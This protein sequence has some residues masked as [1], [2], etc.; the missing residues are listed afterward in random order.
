MKKIKW[1]VY[2]IGLGLLLSF[3]VIGIANANVPSTYTVQSGDSLSGIA[4][5]F[6]GT[7][8]VWKDIYKL[9]PQINNPNLIYIGQIISLDPSIKIGSKSV[10]L[11]PK[12]YSRVEVYDKLIKH[13]FKVN[14]IKYVSREE[15][16]QW[17][18]KSKICLTDYS[19]SNLHEQRLLANKIILYSRDLEFYHLLDGIFE[20]CKND[21]DYRMTALLT[22]LAWQESHFN[23][24]RG[25]HGEITQFQFLPSTIRS[26]LQL[27]DIGLQIV[28][29]DLLNDNNKSAKLAY[30]WLMEN[31]AN[32]SNTLKAL[33][34]YNTNPDYPTY[35]IWKYN[36]IITLIKN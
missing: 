31:G 10:P 17:L 26:V 30:E 4:F 12:V 5:K 29:W 13:I 34:W 33:R 2:L 6:Y 20:A 19:Q 21:T 16:E 32:K 3:F 14:D 28:S 35:V 27:D 36:K 18:S 11:P 25:K 24:V 8:T 1:L 23:N 22:A 7:E 9:N 15:C